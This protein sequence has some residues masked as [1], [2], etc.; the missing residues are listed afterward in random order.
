MATLGDVAAL[1]GVSISAVS[2]VLSNDASA[3]VSATTRTRITEAAKAL[4]YRPNFAGRA[5]KFSRSNVIA[6]I[7]PDLTNAVF[8]ELMRGVE[9]GALERGY[10]VLLARAE[11]MQPGGEMIDRLLGEGRVDG[12]LLQVGD[13]VAP[14]ALASM[15]RAANP[16]V[17]V[18][19]VHP[20]FSGSVTLDDI[21]AGR[22]A[23]E[24]LLTL[25]HTRIA[26][27][28]GLT[29]TH[30]AQQRAIGFREALAAASGAGTAP[31]PDAA[32]DSGPI[33]WHGYEP[34]AGRAALRELMDAAEPP[35]A[36]VVANINAAIGVLGEARVLGIRVPEE[37]SVVAIHDAWTA[38][39]TWPPLTTVRMPLYELGRRGVDAL[40]A[41]LHG[42]TIADTVVSDPPPELLVR[43]STAPPIRR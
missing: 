9:D 42:E 39:N 5:L 6:L 14:E 28:N 11:D 25:G 20:G 33:T 2:R 10:V 43:E 40:Y 4:N 19:S 38:E 21:A 15:L 3:R 24:H 17:L 18:N 41:R 7:V 1:A 8:A 35:T 36:V 13:H 12:V 26:L 22:L 32:A 29:T 37:L 16:T 34:R 23:T 31:G 27:I 30:T